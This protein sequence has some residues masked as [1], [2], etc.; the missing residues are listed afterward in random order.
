MEP[1]SGA[2]YH[3]TLTE[4]LKNLELGVEYKLDLKNEDLQ[5]LSELGSGN[6]GTVTKVLHEKSGRIMAK[7][8]SKEGRYEPLCWGK[9]DKTLLHPIA[10]RSSSMPS[11]LYANRSYESFRSCTN[12]IHN[13]SSASMEPL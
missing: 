4:Q 7:K 3:N 12:A 11:R 10:R 2:S 6:G 1:S 13:T 8:V 5:M 9:A